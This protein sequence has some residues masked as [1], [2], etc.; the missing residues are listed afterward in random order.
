M[1]NEKRKIIHAVYFP[2]AFLMVMWL[3]Y[4]VFVVTGLDMGFFG[5]QPLKP[6]G[7][8]GILLSPFA[9]GSFG[10][11]ISNS[12]SFMVLSVALFYFYRLIAYRIFFINWVIS[13]IL[14]WLGGRNSIHIGASGLVYGLAFFLF[15]SG[16]FRKERKLGAIS[17]IVVFLYGSMIWGLLPQDNHIS[18]EG[19]L[20]G[21]LSG[22]TLAWIYRKRPIDFIPEADGSSVSVTWGRQSMYEY[23]L[24]ENDD[25]ET[26]TPDK[27]V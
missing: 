3:V 4:L 15:F 19:H 22:V 18:W 20:F 21:A 1:I 23:Y 14:L 6:A 9:H 27:P 11:L 7:L 5:I 25:Q 10:H 2:L 16:I 13:G 26:E 12:T 24:Y 17:L 8:W